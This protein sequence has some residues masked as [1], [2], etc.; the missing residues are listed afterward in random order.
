[1]KRKHLVP[2]LLLLALP[3]VAPASLA[4]AEGE[5]VIKAAGTVTVKGDC[6]I[7]TDPNGRKFNLIGKLDAANGEMIRVT[8]K[9]AARTAC[10]DGPAIQIQKVE[11]AKIV[12]SP[13][14]G[15]GAQGAPVVQIETAPEGGGNLGNAPLADGEVRMLRMRGALNEEVKVKGCQGFR[16]LRGELWALTGDLKSFKTGDKVQLEGAQVPTKECGVPTLK[17][18]LIEPFKE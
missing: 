17:L 4:F 8:G 18:T 13:P 1:M 2:S 14:P 3:L 10:L 7:L 16:N 11:K 6:R 15:E 5:E 9:K 12:Q